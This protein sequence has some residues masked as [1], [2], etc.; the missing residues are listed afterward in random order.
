M[1]EGMALAEGMLDYIP[2]VTASAAPFPPPG[3]KYTMKSDAYIESAPEDA[4]IVY[5]DLGEPVSIKINGTQP[6]ETASVDVWDSCN[7]AVNIAE[8]LKT[9]RNEISFESAVPDFPSKYPCN[10][11]PEIVV[12]RGSFSVKKGKVT[13]GAPKIYPGKSWVEQGLPNYMGEV[14]YSKNI[15]LNGNYTDVILDLGDVRDIAE[16]RVNGKSAGTRLWPPYR[17]DI[18]DLIENGENRIEVGVRATGANL[19]SRPR[20]SGLLELPR[21]LVYERQ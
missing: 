18:T 8:L 16:A 13:A 4:E 15:E 9:G 12:L 17:F 5:E 11:A 14:V 19:F 10:H 20:E 3:Q 6:G 7:R 21:L 1:Y 2:A